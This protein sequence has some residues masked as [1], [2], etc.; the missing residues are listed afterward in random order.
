MVL[1]Q[2]YDVNI[3]V[4]VAKFVCVMTHSALFNDDYVNDGRII[5]MTID[6]LV[7]D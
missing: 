6:V 2:W 5:C 1:D 3:I 7:I 4:P